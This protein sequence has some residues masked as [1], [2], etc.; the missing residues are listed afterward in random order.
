MNKANVL[1]ARV[2][3]GVAVLLGILTGYL[4]VLCL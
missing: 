2:T 4:I 3:E 1:Y